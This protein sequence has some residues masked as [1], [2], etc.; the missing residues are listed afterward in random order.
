MKKYTVYLE[1]SVGYEIDRKASSEDISINKYLKKIIEKHLAG[2]VS[3]ADRLDKYETNLYEMQLLQGIQSEFI[4]ECMRILFTRT[5]LL[6]NA[7][8]SVD[9]QLPDSNVMID[10]AKDNIDHVIK[11]SVLN[12]KHFEDTWKIDEFFN[13]E[14]EFV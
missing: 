11:K 2:D 13:K 14:G 7:L 6:I 9:C 5:D 1:D 4:K 3:I 10:K 12:T 8:K